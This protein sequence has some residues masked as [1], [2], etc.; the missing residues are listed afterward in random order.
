MACYY[1]RFG[2]LSISMKETH[3]ITITIYDSI[4]DRL[5]IKKVKGVTT[6]PSICSQKIALLSRKMLLKKVE[7]TP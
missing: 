6:V 7:E 5:T 4:A 1:R 3:V 2:P